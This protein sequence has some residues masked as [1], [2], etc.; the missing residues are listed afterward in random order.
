MRDDTQAAAVTPGQDA[1]F[2]RGDLGRPDLPF[3]AFSFCIFKEFLKDLLKRNVQS[4]QPL[5][6][7]AF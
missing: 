7:L 2:L 1:G 4:T 5:E 3:L 6:T